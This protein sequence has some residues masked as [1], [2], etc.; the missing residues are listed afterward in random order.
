VPDNK[1]EKT[2][3]QG[4]KA[5]LRAIGAVG[6]W[7][8]VFLAFLATG[9]PGLFHAASSGKPDWQSIQSATVA[10]GPLTIWAAVLT[11]GFVR[12]WFDDTNPFWVLILSTL[13]MAL[14]TVAFDKLFGGSGIDR[15]NLPE[16]T[17]FW[18]WM[19]HQFSVGGFLVGT[20]RAYY[21]K[22]GPGLFASALV[23]GVFYGWA[24]GGKLWPRL[25][26]EIAHPGVAAAAS[27]SQLKKVKR[28]SRRRGEAE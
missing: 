8:S 9:L 18:G 23:V 1:S 14:V 6:F 17:G 7:V 10:T 24:V 2:L 3:D 5:D 12:R 19:S 4:L 16:L 22:Y 20:C 11:I 27:S 13:L 28:K 25:A 21:M 15:K 26:N